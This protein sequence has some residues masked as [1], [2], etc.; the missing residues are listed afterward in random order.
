MALTMTARAKAPDPATRS[1]A[2]GAV[3]GAAVFLCDEQGRV[4]GLTAGAQAL[5]EEDGGLA[6]RAGV[7]MTTVD[8]L[9]LG[10]GIRAAR[11]GPGQTL[12]IPSPAGPALVLD[13]T[14][15][16]SE[17]PGLRTL[18][19]VSARNHS[20]APGDLE[21]VLLASFG[22][23]AAEADIAIRLTRGATRSAIAVARGVSLGTVKSQIK[24]VYQKVGV[25]REVELAACLASLL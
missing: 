4:R 5:L 24:S 2:T 12:F 23:T 15:L 1:A 18:V 25:T 10:E 22:L 16:L 21:A 11:G 7:L 13:V 9:D 20:A 19:V 17:A 14:P 6:L 8:E 3:R